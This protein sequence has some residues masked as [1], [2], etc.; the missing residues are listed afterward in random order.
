MCLCFKLQHKASCCPTSRNDMFYIFI[1]QTVLWL[2]CVH[3]HPAVN[4]TLNDTMKLQWNDFI[5][6]SWHEQSILLTLQN[7]WRTHLIRELWVSMDNPAKSNKQS[8]LYLRGSRWR[9]SHVP[10]FQRCTRFLGMLS[11]SVPSLLSFMTLRSH[12]KTRVSLPG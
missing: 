11:W 12:L 3:P 7:N 2:Y 4:A 6:V 10:F 8:T 5:K 1:A 9:F